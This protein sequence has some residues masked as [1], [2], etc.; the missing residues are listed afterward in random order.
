MSIFELLAVV[1][2]MWIFIIKPYNDEQRMKR[3]EEI[4]KQGQRSVLFDQ[5]Y[6]KED[7][8]EKEEC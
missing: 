7:E 4:Y 2:I 1:W 5:M 8:E 3:E 6:A